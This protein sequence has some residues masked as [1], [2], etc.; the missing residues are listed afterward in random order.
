MLS[1]RPNNADA[2]NQPSFRTETNGFNRL[3]IYDKTDRCLLNTQTLQ[4]KFEQTATTFCKQATT[5][6]VVGLGMY[7]WP[8]DFQHN[9]LSKY[10]FDQTQRHLEFMNEMM[11]LIKEKARAYLMWH[12]L[13]H[14]VQRRTT[15]RIFMSLNAPLYDDLHRGG[16]GKS[17]I[18]DHDF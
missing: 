14:H 15:T 17:E 1:E 5:D 18:I 2:S 7:I 6:C 3:V 4:E 12:T 13:E 11:E 9:L 16:H 10:V 8:R